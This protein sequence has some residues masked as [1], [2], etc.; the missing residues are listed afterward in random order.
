MTSF[1]RYFDTSAILNNPKLKNGWILFAPLSILSTLILLYPVNLTHTFSSIQSLSA[2]PNLPLFIV[3]FILWMVL[4]VFTISITTKM[5]QAAILSIIFTLVF[6]GFWTIHWRNGAWEDWVRMIPDSQLITFFGRVPLEVQGYFEWPGASIWGSVLTNVMGTTMP[7]IRIPL[8][9]G[10]LVLYAVLLFVLYLRIFNEPRLATISVIISI[11]GNVILSRFHL[12][13]SFFVLVPLV[14]FLWVT[15]RLWEQKQ[16]N[17]SLVI[18]L[19]LLG[20]VITVTHFITS[21][22]VLLVILGFWLSKKKDVRS[23]GNMFSA[24]LIF[25][26]VLMIVSWQ[27]YCA[28]RNFQ[29]Q[30]LDAAEFLSNMIQGEFSSLLNY[31]GAVATGNV[32]HSPFWANFVRIAWL[33]LLYGFGLIMAILVLVRKQFQ[34]NIVYASAGLLAVAVLAVVATIIGQEGA[35]YYRLITYGSLLAP[36]VILLVIIASHYSRWI[37]AVTGLILVV[38]AVPTFLANNSRVITEAYYSQEITAGKFLAQN[39]MK[40]NQQ[41]VFYGSGSAEIARYYG[42]PGS[43]LVGAGELGGFSGYDSAISSV[44]NLAAQF[45]TKQDKENSYSAVSQRLANQFAYALDK[46]GGQQVLQHYLT[47]LDSA[48]RIYDNGLAYIYR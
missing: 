29:W 34:S 3:F 22:F 20:A 9:C 5:N 18:I 37:L 42:P 19:L 21:I 39:L 35:Q 13:P 16:S 48:D 25:L 43:N 1:L 26:V 23:T 32:S 45:Q 31:T 8:I 44:T 17:I 47:A 41:L 36:V 4:L 30:L 10:L 24:N 33:V 11:V 7:D 46:D 15:F 27:M 12:Q 14:A 2:I 28:I 6:V 40:N 38:A